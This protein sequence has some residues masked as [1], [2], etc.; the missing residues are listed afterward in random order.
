MQEQRRSSYS[1]RSARRRRF[2]PV[3]LIVAILPFVLVL[4]LY[5]RAWDAAPRFAFPWNTAQWFA[6]LLP[7]SAHTTQPA[8]PTFSR[9]W[10]IEGPV[11]SKVGDMQALGQQ[12]VR[13]M[14]TS[15]QCSGSNYG[16][17]VILDFG[18]P[19]TSQGVYGTYTVK[20][21]HFW[22]DTDIADGAK[23]YMM[24]WHT[25][26]S[27]CKVKLA[28][29]LSNHHQC[30]YNGPS[31]SITEVG[32][33]WADTVNSLNTWVKSR[34]YDKQIQVWGAYDAE[35]TWDGADRQSRGGQMRTG[36]T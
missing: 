1:Y 25:L 9:S 16:S 32:T 8:R 35:T 2:S 26:S 18:E 30:A 14:L 36:T 22:S 34:N 3:A 15:R 11:A 21:N 19:H 31:C 10:Y 28:I 29:G 33:Q 4:F 27:A 20:T 13:W 12:D 17:L 6:A 7:V 23:Q 5:T 24:A